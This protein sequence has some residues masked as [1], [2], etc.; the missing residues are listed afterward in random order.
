MVCTGVILAACAG[1]TT[2]PS[3]EICRTADCFAKQTQKELREQ[4]HRDLTRYP[5]SRSARKV[6]DA[7]YRYPFT[8]AKTYYAWVRYGGSGP[9]PF[10]WCKH[11]A[12]QVSVVAYNR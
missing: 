1:Q 7:K 3:P 12:K 2:E 10:E 5:R 4:C 8:D 11:Y 9:S 6:V